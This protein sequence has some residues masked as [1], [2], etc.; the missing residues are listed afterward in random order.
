MTDPGGFV[1]QSRI[2]PVPHTADRTGVEPVVSSVTGRRVNHYTNGPHY[3]GQ[4]GRRVNRY[5]MSPLGE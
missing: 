3:A 2:R 1:R 4:A 5:T